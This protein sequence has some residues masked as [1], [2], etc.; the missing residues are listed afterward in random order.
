MNADEL[1]AFMAARAPSP[2]R[3]I[4]GLACQGCAHSAAGAPPPGEPS[5]ERPCMACIRNPEAEPRKAKP[6][7]ILIDDRGNARCFDPFAGTQYNGVPYVHHPAD[8][9]VTLDSGDQERWLDEHP[10]YRGAIGFDKDGNPRVL[11]E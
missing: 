7:T 11:P 10:E 1:I 3:H 2:H 6:G 9:Y 5:G 8:R 4:K